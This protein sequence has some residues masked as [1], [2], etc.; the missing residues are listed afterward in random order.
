M[1]STPCYGL[2]AGWRGGTRSLTLRADMVSTVLVRAEKVCPWIG[3]LVSSIA[4]VIWGDFDN[5]CTDSAIVL[6]TPMTVQN[7]VALCRAGR[8][9]LLLLWQ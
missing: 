2:L 9:N 3:S 7:L 5:S 4:K 1:F 6:F 8:S